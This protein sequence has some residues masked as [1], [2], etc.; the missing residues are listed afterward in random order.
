MKDLLERMEEF[1]VVHVSK[2]KKKI[3]DDMANLAMRMNVEWKVFNE[4]C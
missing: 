3:A 2:Q 1:R 4:P